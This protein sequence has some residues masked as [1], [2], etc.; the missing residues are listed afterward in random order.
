LEIPTAVLRV[1]EDLDYE[2][3]DLRL[4][5]SIGEALMPVVRELST[6][7]AGKDDGSTSVGL[8]GVLFRFH[9]LE[10]SGT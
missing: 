10:R 7:F 1:F 4:L 9:D 8:D 5:P 6:D 3:G 2:P